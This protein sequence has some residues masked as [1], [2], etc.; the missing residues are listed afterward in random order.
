[1]S[2]HFR[3]VPPAPGPPAQARARLKPLLRDLRTREVSGTL[4]PLEHSSKGS[5]ELDSRRTPTGLTTPR[6]TLRNPSSRSSPKG[7]YYSSLRRQRPTQP[8]LFRRRQPPSSGVNPTSRRPHLVSPVFFFERAPLA[9]VPSWFVSALSWLLD[10]AVVDLSSLLRPFSSSPL[11]V[12]VVNPFPSSP[13]IASLID[14]RACDSLAREIAS[15]M[16]RP[17][18]TRMHPIA[19][20]FATLSSIWMSERDHH[21]PARMQWHDASG[22]QVRVRT[23]LCGSRSRESEGSDRQVGWRPGAYGR[24]RRPLES[25]VE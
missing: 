24:P 20:I 8:E 16:P 14:T 5:R 7:L 25:R 11:R 9:G 19:T 12:S 3:Y 21:Q 18:L 6:T 15:M 1:M 17:V 10:E 13:L 22:R 23:W 2:V 4:L